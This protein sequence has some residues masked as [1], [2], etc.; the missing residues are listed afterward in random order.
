[1]R[2]GEVFWG[3]LLVLLGVL[4]FLQ[5]AGYLTGDVFSWFWPI[6]I[7]AIGLWILFGGFI[8]RVDFN[9]A[10]TFSIPMQDAKEARLEMNHGAGQIE[11]S[12]GAKLGDFLTGVAGVAMDHSWRLDGAKLEV[13]IDAGPS[14]IPFIGPEGGVWQFRLNP[15]LPVSLDIDAGASRLNLDL[16]DLQVRYLSFDGGASRINLT[17][18]ARVENMICDL[19]AGAASIDLNV[20]QGVGLRLRLKSVGALHI[21]EGRFVPR[22]GRIYQSADYDAAKY[23]ADVTIEGGA[24]SIR[25]S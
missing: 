18:P 7:I 17:L 12:A 11:L 20:P 22:E 14:F 23:R 15:D 16:H 9:N 24:T 13:K 6:V 21:D 2:R 3:S 19:E 8:A 5:T 25:V 4:F 10:E 1:M